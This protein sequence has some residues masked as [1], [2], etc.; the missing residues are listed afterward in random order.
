MSV[1][2]QVQTKQ[3]VKN[4]SLWK[5]VLHNDDFTPMD[6]VTQVLVEIFGKSKAEAE[7]IMLTVHNMGKANVGLYTKEIAITKITQVRLV[8]ENRG[9][10][11]LA[12][13]EEA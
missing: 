1:A 12:T 4:P 8:S 6:F 5:V 10:P 3:T 7:E 11:L 2:T 9:H 13:A